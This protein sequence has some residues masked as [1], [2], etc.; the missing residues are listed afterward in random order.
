MEMPSP[1]YVMP[2]EIFYNFNLSEEAKRLFISIESYTSG[3]N[4]QLEETIYNLLFLSREKFEDLLSELVLWK[5]L[6]V[7]IIDDKKI[8]SINYDIISMYSEPAKEVYFLSFDNIKLKDKKLKAKQFFIETL[9]TIN[10]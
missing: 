5:Y 7:N 2:R 9:S 8:I 6:S 10:Q 4:L 3:G 1:Y